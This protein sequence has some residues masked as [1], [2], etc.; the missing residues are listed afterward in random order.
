MRTITLALLALAASSCAHVRPVDRA[1][2]SRAADLLHCRAEEVR[3]LSTV[4]AAPAAHPHL[5]AQLAGGG[6]SSAADGTPVVVT[7][8]TVPVV[9]LFAGLFLALD[10]LKVPRPQRR[11]SVRFYSGCGATV[12]CSDEEG[13]APPRGSASTPVLEA[14]A[15]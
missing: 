3:D 14:F 11:P 12:R 9:G 7:A 2:L 5:G 13:C 10:R 1:E 4:A 6:D 15:R 8:V